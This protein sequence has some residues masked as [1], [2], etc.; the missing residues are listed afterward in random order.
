MK[1]YITLNFLKTTKIRLKSDE[2]GI[3][4]GKIFRA[5]RRMTSHLLQNSLAFN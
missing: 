2:G 5:I 1:V 4:S 3:V